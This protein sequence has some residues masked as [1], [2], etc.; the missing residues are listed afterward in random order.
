MP[1]GEISA[2][3]GSL[4]LVWSLR[5]AVSWMGMVTGWVAPS[6]SGQLGEETATAVH[7]G[8]D[9]KVAV[10]VDHQGLCVFLPPPGVESHAS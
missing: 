4:L 5:M 2:P 9:V 10:R 7:L 1:E 8:D 6:G 3:W